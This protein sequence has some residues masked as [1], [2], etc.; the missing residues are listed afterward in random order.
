MNV[1][2][3][4]A[5]CREDSMGEYLMAGPLRIEHEAAVIYSGRRQKG[6]ALNVD[7]VAVTWNTIINPDTNRKCSGGRSLVS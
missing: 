2:S 7:K 5:S 4:R 1:G 6:Q 3:L